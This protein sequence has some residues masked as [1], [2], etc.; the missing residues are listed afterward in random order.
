MAEASDD[1]RIPARERIIKIE[2]D[3]L[4]SSKLTENLQ[5]VCNSIESF[6]EDLEASTKVKDEFVFK[7]MK[8]WIQNSENSNYGREYLQAVADLGLFIM[9]HGFRIAFQ[10][11][12]IFLYRADQVKV[13][14]DFISY[15]IIFTSPCLKTKLK[16]KYFK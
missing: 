10:P 14:V 5:T 4:Q 8:V 7:Q 1:H 2:T 11:D 15:K 9:T 13:R 16:L 12:E 3:F 6:F